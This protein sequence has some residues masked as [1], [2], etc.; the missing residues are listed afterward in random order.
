VLAQKL[1]RRTA[2][3]PVNVKSGIVDKDAGVTRRRA[4]LVRA[5]EDPGCI[6]EDI[7]NEIA[8]GGRIAFEATAETP[9]EVIL[10]L[11]WP[12]DRGRLRC[13]LPFPARG[14]GFIDES[15]RWLRPHARIALD[16]L[17]GVRAIAPPDTGEGV[18]FGWL[19][20]PDVQGGRGLWV[21]RR[22]SDECP[23]S[24]LRQ[25]FLR[26][27]ASSQKLDASVVLAVQG[28]GESPPFRLSRLDLV[29]N[30]IGD[31]VTIDG[32]HAAIVATEDEPSI[33]LFCRPI[34]DFSKEEEPLTPVP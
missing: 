1:K 30:I 29:F 22:F 33:E 24:S 17:Y 15:G 27:L 34:G 32:D 23:L 3:E 9:G 12:G 2:V 20:A 5:I 21:R 10:V 8:G 14:G 4:G 6:H 13:H 7:R 18:L 26:L 11:V 31:E 19:Q 16:S 25:V 28:D